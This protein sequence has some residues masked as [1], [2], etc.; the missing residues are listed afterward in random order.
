MKEDECGKPCYV[1]FGDQIKYEPAWMT[2]N[3][4]WKLDQLN[5][6]D[7]LSSTTGKNLTKLTYF[8]LPW[9][10]SRYIIYGRNSADRYSRLSQSSHS[11]MHHRLIT[12]MHL[13]RTTQL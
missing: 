12:I 5:A 3:E 7:C 13:N 10:K 2:S 9:I 8:K 1:M 4:K 6:K 11:R